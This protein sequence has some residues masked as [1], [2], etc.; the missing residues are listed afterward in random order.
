MAN[1]KFYLFSQRQKTFVTDYRLVRLLLFML[2]EN[3]QAVLYERRTLHSILKYLKQI[4]T[5]YLLK[6]KFC[7]LTQILP[8]YIVL[9]FN[10]NNLF[11]NAELT[12]VARGKTILDYCSYFVFLNIT[13]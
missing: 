1:R 3:K 10:S 5:I 12:S 6:N 4:I 13:G 9:Y 2:F 8:G 11:R 7:Q